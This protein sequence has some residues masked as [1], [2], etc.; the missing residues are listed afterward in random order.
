M[1]TV[2]IHKD[3]EGFAARWGETLH[4]RGVSLRWL[5]LLGSDPLNDVCGCDGVMWHWAHYP[6][7]VRLAARPILYVIEKEMKIPVFPDLRTAWHYDDKISQSYLLQ[8][9]GIPTPRTWIF[10]DRAEAERWAEAAPYPVVAKLAMGAGSNNVKLIR[11]IGEGREHIASMFSRAGIIGIGLHSDKSTVGGIVKD[12]AQ[13]LIWGGR[14]MLRKKYPPLPKQFWMPQRGYALFQ[15]FL[16]DNA[17]DTRV[18]VVG[19]RAFGFCRM[20]R[21]DDFR[22]SGSG[23]IDPDPLKIDPQCIELAFSAAKKL[24]SQ[25]MAFDLLYA[26]SGHMPV[27]VEIS[28]CYANWAVESCPGHWDSRMVWHEGRMWPEEAHVVDFLDAIQAAKSPNESS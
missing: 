24:G 3:S 18:T 14:Y 10:W 16:P 26:G 27:V 1:T 8:A 25:S 7:E 4:D 5:N 13:R 9:L 6:H 23:V 19:D 22:A 11:N 2:G 20:N 28:Y 12:I 15:E 21:P 17:F